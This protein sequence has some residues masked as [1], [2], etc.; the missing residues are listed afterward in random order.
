MVMDILKNMMYAGLGIQE[1][2]KEFVLDLV[3]RGELNNTQAS[4]LIKE[5]STI[6][7]EH[8]FELPQSISEMI[9]KT[10]SRM[11]LPTKS[12]IANLNAKI[13]ALTAKIDAGKKY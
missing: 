13:D 8:S 1:K 4:K 5:W 9:E 12:D 6:V 7:D 3:K 10:L 2:M 11:N